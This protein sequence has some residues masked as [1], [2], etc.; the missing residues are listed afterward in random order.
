MFVTL[1]VVFEWFVACS[2][3]SIVWLF[4]WV[5]FC[6]LGLVGCAVVLCIGL[7]FVGFWVS[8]WLLMWFSWVIHSC[9]LNDW[10]VG[11]L[12]AWICVDVYC[13]ACY[14]V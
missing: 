13:C 12:S 4:G 9:L 11:W 14:L 5:C 3:S 6:V 10:W 1:S 8:D 2:F 7:L